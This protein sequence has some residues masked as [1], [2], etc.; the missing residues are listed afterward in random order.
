[1]HN[2]CLVVEPCSDY[3]LISVLMVSSPTQL[4]QR[5]AALATMAHTTALNAVQLIHWHNLCCNTG[6]R[7]VYFQAGDSYSRTA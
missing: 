3:N 4:Q 1:M 7:L 6:F 5:T 2:F